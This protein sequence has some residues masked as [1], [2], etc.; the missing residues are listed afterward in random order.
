MDNNK[1]LLFSAAPSETRHSQP[2]TA[3]PSPASPRLVPP[4]TRASGNLPYPPSAPDASFRRRMPATGNAI[5][6][7]GTFV[8]TSKTEVDSPSVS[9]NSHSPPPPLGVQGDR[10]YNWHTGCGTPRQQLSLAA[11]KPFASLS[12]APALSP[13]QPSA[14][15]TDSDIDD[16]DD[17]DISLQSDLSELPLELE[18]TAPAVVLFTH[19]PHLRIHHAGTDN[20]AIGNQ[21]S[22][23][24]ITKDSRPNLGSK[25]AA[26]DSDTDV[27]S[28]GESGEDQGDG[29][30]TGHN[31]SNQEALQATGGPLSCPYRKRNKKRFNYRTHRG[32][33]AP[34]KTISLVKLEG[35]ERRRA[36]EEPQRKDVEDGITPQVENILIERQGASKVCTWES[37]WKALFPNDTEIPS[38]G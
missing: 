35:H 26:P 20:D 7:D 6:G 32:C 17:D 21:T 24:R 16:D 14:S 36:T 33:T 29:S 18:G 3:S 11:K 1:S 28:D 4:S 37:L 15:S 9:Y 13:C 10:S 22:K 12:D 34:F 38:Q 2:L 8:G 25:R 19:Q 31:L 30:G 5:S 27:Q 23:T